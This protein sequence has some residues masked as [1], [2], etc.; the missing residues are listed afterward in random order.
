MK[1][2][3]N[4]ETLA[5][6]PIDHRKSKIIEKNNEY[7][8]DYSPYKVMEHSCSYFG[9]SLQGRLEGSKN[10]LGSIYKAPVVVEESRNIVFF[11]TMSPTLEENSWISLNNIQ[12]YETKGYKT[13]IYFDNDKKIEI[14]VPLLSIENQVLRATRLSLIHNKRKNIEKSNN[15]S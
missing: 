6:L 7:E 15:F 14:D 3:I 11:P 10:I 12:K 5:I 13:V 8:I 1:Y 2:E 4:S 9:S